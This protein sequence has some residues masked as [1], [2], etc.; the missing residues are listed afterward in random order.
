[1]G[2]LVI[3]GR[4]YILMFRYS[5]C[6]WWGI[7]YQRWFINSAIYW[8]E[9]PPH[10]VAGASRDNVIDLKSLVKAC[11]RNP[12]DV[13]R[14][15]QVSNSYC[16]TIC[17]GLALHTMVGS[18]FKTNKSLN[19]KTYVRRR[20]LLIFASKNDDRFAT[21]FWLLWRRIMWISLMTLWWSNKFADV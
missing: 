21:A 6:G 2:G 17:L 3:G 12:G 16:L 15:F 19:K 18:M 11:A 5:M 4:D 8:L 7:M 10:S 1:M 14:E 13:S 20:R 9:S